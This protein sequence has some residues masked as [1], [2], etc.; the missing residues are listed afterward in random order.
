MATDKMDKPRFEKPT[1]EMRHCEC[2][3]YRQAAIWS[4]G[5]QS[6]AGGC[7]ACD[8]IERLNILLEGG[9]KVRRGSN[10]TMDPER[11]KGQR[12]R[13]EA[14]V[15]ILK[16]E[17]STLTVERNNALTEVRRAQISAKAAQASAER[18][19]QG[20]KFARAGG[21]DWN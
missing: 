18:V 16:K 1:Y 20:C 8:T 2:G 14:E 21:P 12:D 9:I 10:A 19:R 7:R 5:R 4:D 13:A 6:W 17:V 11:L 15:E 3:A